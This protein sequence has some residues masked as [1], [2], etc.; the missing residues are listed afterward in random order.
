MAE[1]PSPQNKATSTVIVY[2]TWDTVLTSE[3]AFETLMLYIHF[4]VRAV[5]LMLSM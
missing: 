4:V 5:I 1:Q 3:L 2:S